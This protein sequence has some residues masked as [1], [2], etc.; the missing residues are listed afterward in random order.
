MS[1]EIL[2]CVDP[3]GRVACNLLEGLLGDLPEEVELAC[4][5]ISLLEEQKD[6]GR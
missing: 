6:Q 1:Q 2:R 4:S 5:F 3:A